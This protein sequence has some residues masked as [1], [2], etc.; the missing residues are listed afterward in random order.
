MLKK[1]Q[2][3]LVK[4]IH[5]FWC[6]RKYGWYKSIWSINQY[7][8]VNASLVINDEKVDFDKE[9]NFNLYTMFL[10]V[11]LEKKKV[12]IRTTSIRSNTFRL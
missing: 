10:V 8:F 11:N 2:I 9:G 7:R 12:E 1:V 6:C 5:Q 4:L 3:C